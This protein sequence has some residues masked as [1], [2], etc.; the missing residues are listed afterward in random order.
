M[1][2]LVYAGDK[3]EDPIRLLAKHFLM[4]VAG[5][6]VVYTFQN[7]NYTYITKILK[8]MLILSILLLIVALGVGFFHK[9]VLKL[10]VEEDPLA[11]GR[12]IPLPFGFT[13]QPSEMA[14][15]ITIMFVAMQLTLFQG[16]LKSYETFK[17]ILSLPFII[18]ILIL[19]SNI[20]SALILF[21]VIMLLLFISSV[22][23]K[24]LLS[25]LIIMITVLVLMFIIVKAV[26]EISEI[27][28]FQRFSSGNTRLQGNTSNDPK[29]QTHITQVAIGNA[30]FL[31]LGIGNSVMANHQTEAHNDFIF[32]VIVEEGGFLLGFIVIMFYMILVYRCFAIAKRA[33]GLFGALVSL[34][35]GLVFII[36]ALVHISVSIG[37]A[38]VT[39]Q[40]LPFIS[41]GGT[42]QLFACFALGVVLNISAKGE[43][44]DTYNNEIT[45]ESINNTEIQM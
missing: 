31:G 37:I 36:Q 24:Y 11:S 2:N 3:I 18:F 43:Q 20:S 16:K 25:T 15:Y 22:R 29:H 45:E 32:M 4:L 33:K 28:P 19:S 13:F 7:F 9:Y 21:V 40:T 17:K 26:P 10:S 12:W 41:K 27:P 1:G 30:G 23:L 34:G 8:P 39:G 44:E 35:I 14:K 6:V 42:S 5:F 38:P